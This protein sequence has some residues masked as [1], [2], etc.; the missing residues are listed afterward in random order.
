M[1]LFLR[2]TGRWRSWVRTGFNKILSFLYFKWFI[3]GRTDTYIAL[4]LHCIALH[5]IAL[6]CIALH[7]IALHCVHYITLRYV[8]CIAYILNVMLIVRHVCSW[9]VPSVTFVNSLPLNVLPPIG[10]VCLSVC[11]CPSRFFFGSGPPTDR[12]TCCMRLNWN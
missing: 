6:H 12:L 8:H 10:S 1:T 11:V 2:R 3:H 7:C 4:H 9:I 5:C